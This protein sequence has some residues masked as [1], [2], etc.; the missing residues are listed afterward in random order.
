V[1]R[2]EFQIRRE[3]LKECSIYAVE[4]LFEKED[5]LWAYLTSNWLEL[6]ENIGGNVSRRPLDERWKK[7][8]NA[9]RK[10]E[11]SPLIRERVIQGDIKRLLDQ[12]VGI[13]FSVG[14]AANKTSMEEVLE[15]L[16]KWGENKLLK[17][18]IT[19]KDEV[20]ARRQRFIMFER[21]RSELSPR[22]FNVIP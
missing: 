4:D 17:E 11:V 8:Q 14:A 9:K 15:M 22:G 3:F 16:K 18:G 10:L 7:V 12:G 20:Q 21:R 1:W 5:S 19:F 2:I 13:L 6:R